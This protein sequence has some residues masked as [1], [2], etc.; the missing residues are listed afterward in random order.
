VEIREVKRVAEGTRFRSYVLVALPTGT[1][2]ALQT[3]KDRMRLNDRAEQRS[4]EAFKDLDRNT[5]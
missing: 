3:R 5:Q 4:V 1:A 2:N